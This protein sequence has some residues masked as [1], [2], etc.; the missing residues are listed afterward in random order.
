M[1][2]SL[3]LIL[4]L[5]IA[6]IAARLA[7]F[8][9]DRSEFVY[10]TQ[11]G[12]PVQ[13]YDGAND[14]DA[15]LHV[16]WPWPIQSVQRLDRRLQ[17]FDLPG[18]ELLTRD[19]KGN[20]I[21]KTLTIDAYVCWRI[22]GNPGGV[23][24]FIRSVGTPEGA[25]A[26]LGQRINSELGAAVGRMELD[27]LVSIEPGK[28]D[29]KRD[30]L[31]EQLLHGDGSSLQDVAR[32][33]YG[34]DV[35]D[36]RLRRTNHPVAVQQAIFSRIVSERNKKVAD[37]RSEGER[38]AADIRSASDRRVADL[39]SAADAEAIRLR[40]QADAE[41]D[42]IRNEAAARD[43]QFYAFL[44]KLEDYQR[45]LGD[46]KTML[47]LSTHRELFDTLFQ[48]PTPAKSEGRQ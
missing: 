7:L 48:P 10:L 15:G 43:P 3:A 34:I 8:T 1:R 9:V 24:R 20:T 26:I 11:L 46:N 38:Q 39:K 16:K 22:D 36:I 27:D 47:L 23:D 44:R 12:R 31:R 14:A 40:G 18:A 21:D 25:K 45:I 4:C 19:A 35:V 5:I 37:Y 2:Y 32:R 30:A 42:R 17:Y 33:E 41:A 13:T 29:R 6:I 28:V